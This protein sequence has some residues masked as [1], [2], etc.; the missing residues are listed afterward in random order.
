MVLGSGVGDRGLAASVMVAMLA[1]TASANPPV[2]PPPQFD[3]ASLVT[4]CAE[5]T[6]LSACF[7]GANEA[8]IAKCFRDC[9]LELNERGE[10][11]AA[12]AQGACATTSKSTASLARVSRSSRRTRPASGAWSNAR[13]LRTSIPSSRGVA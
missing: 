6:T 12:A 9:V 10:K 2:A 11:A 1:A 5:R 3:V 8:E 13:A 4:R 7:A